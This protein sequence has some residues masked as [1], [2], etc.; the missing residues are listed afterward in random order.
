MLRMTATEN[1][2]E[3]YFYLHRNRFMP[4]GRF[5]PKNQLAWGRTRQEGADAWIT[6]AHRSDCRT[7]S[8]GG[9]PS[10]QLRIVLQNL[11]PRPLTVDIQDIKVHM[12]S[13][14][15]G[16]VLGLAGN[17]AEAS[18]A[19]KVVAFNGEAVSTVAP[20]DQQWIQL[21]MF[22]FAVVAINIE[23]KGC[24]FEA[25]FLER[26]LTCCHSILHPWTL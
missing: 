4:R 15:M 22:E 16:R 7:I 1:F 21:Q 25:D 18:L 20:T 13:G 10:I 24:E 26:Y 12:K 11:L 3:L 9:T 2:Y 6:I 8:R 23:C 14:Y 5:T 17:A 19:P